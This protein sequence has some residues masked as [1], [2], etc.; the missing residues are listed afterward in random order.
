[1]LAVYRAHQGAR[2]SRQELREC[3]L[4]PGPG[5]HERWKAT[6]AG[7]KGVRSQRARRRGTMRRAPVRAKSS[8]HRDVVTLSLARAAKVYTCPGL[9]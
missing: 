6:P 3:G 7:L 1:M 9:R 4:H 8:C 2:G 5:R